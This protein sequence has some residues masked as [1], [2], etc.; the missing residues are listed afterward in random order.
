MESLDRLGRRGVLVVHLLETAPQYGD[1]V[2]TLPVGNFVGRPGVFEHQGVVAQEAVGLALQQGRPLAG[3]GPVDGL[4]SRVVDRQNIL[5]VYD[6]A[7]IEY[8]EAR[9]AMSSI[10]WPTVPGT[11]WK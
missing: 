5:T 10:G 6:L 8:E 1:R 9:D 3:A 7:S 2:P 4:L 11:V